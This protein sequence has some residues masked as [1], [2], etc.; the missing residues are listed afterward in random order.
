MGELPHQRLAYGQRTFTYCGMDYYFGPML[1]TIGRRPAKRWGVIFT[2]L[3][4][5]AIH[6]ELASSNATSSA[7]KSLRRILSRRGQPTEIY[8][9]NGINLVGTNSELQK[10]L[11]DGNYDDIVEKMTNRGIKW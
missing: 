9:D 11:I 4:T 2:C 10:A 6:L 5:R 3:K 1:V 8:S 7:I